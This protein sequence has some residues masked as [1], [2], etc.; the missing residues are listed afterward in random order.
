MK[1]APIYAILSIVRCS[2]IPFSSIGKNSGI[3]L[4]FRPDCI[5]IYTEDGEKIRKKVIIGIYNNKIAKNGLY[6]GL[7]G[8]NLLNKSS[9][10]R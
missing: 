4:G 2:I 5:K 3:I 8:L 10:D 9:K 7:I 6:S 1:N